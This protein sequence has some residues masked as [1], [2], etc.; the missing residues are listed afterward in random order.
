MDEN[1][2]RK[3]LAASGGGRVGDGRCFFTFLNAK[4]YQVRK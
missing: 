2:L 3:L 1:R 4:M